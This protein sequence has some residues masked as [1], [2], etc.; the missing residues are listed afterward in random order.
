MSSR[1]LVVDAGPNA[2]ILWQ[3]LTSLFNTLNFNDDKYEM[4]DA[5]SQAVVRCRTAISSKPISEDFQSRGIKFFEKRHQQLKWK[6]QEFV[7]NYD[8]VRIS[9]ILPPFK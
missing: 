5:M 8:R 3:R 7:S 1:D 2:D 9:T 4:N 6:D